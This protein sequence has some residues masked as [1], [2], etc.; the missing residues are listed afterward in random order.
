MCA[1]VDLD[2]IPCFAIYYGL[3]GERNPPIEGRKYWFW[4]NMLQESVLSTSNEYPSDISP[5]NPL[6]TLGSDA[7]LDKIETC[8]HR[9]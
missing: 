2:N 6:I 9:Q 8:M 4:T 7:F 1:F 5:D 3:R